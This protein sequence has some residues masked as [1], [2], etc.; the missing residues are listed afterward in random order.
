MFG[1][2]SP[3]PPLVG[4]VPAQAVTLWAFS[5]PGGGAPLPPKV[6]GHFR[7]AGLWPAA[8][9]LAKP[10]W[11]T[12]FASPSNHPAADHRVVL[13]DVSRARLAVLVR[14]AFLAIYMIYGNKLEARHLVSRQ[15]RIIA[16]RF[17]LR[18]GVGAQ[19]E[20]TG[21]L[22][23]TPLRS[24]DFWADGWAAPFDVG[25]DVRSL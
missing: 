13:R 2:V 11:E 7:S 20:I 19:S 17:G 16:G 15:I 14:G 3:G 22:A 21:A 12:A 25:D 6:A 4:L 8:W 23:E 9:T 10:R 24:S 5:P 18:P 1:S